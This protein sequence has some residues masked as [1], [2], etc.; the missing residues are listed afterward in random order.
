MRKILIWK[1]LR[2]RPKP[3]TPKPFFAKAEIAKADFAKKPTPFFLF[4][5]SQRRFSRKKKPKAVCQSRLRCY[6]LSRVD[7]T[8]NAIAGIGLPAPKA[9]VGL[10]PRGLS[11][12]SDRIASP[13]KVRTR[14][15]LRPAH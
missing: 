7:L 4:L 2:K 15:A 3:K 1:N 12:F 8:L 10:H 14:S 5:K 9:L 13:L 6:T 11:L